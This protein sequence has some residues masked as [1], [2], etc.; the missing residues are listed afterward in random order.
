MIESMDNELPKWEGAGRA[1]VIEV[2]TVEI[3]GADVEEKEVRKGVEEIDQLVYIVL[4][5]C[6]LLM[7][8]WTVLRLEGEARR[9]VCNLDHRGRY[10]RRNSTG[11][12]VELT[13]SAE[14]GLAVCDAR[15]IG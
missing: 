1:G 11:G 9:T 3:G 14:Q 13:L 5:R 10:E 12:H 6:P 2:A 15:L 7:Q 8:A 4:G